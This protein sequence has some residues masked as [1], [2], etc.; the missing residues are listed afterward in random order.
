MGGGALQEAR[1]A[2]GTRRRHAAGLVL[3]AIALAAT[4]TV[5][6]TTEMTDGSGYRTAM[7]AG[8]AG[9]ARA[10]CGNDQYDSEFHYWPQSNLGATAKSAPQK[11]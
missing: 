2:C 9:T 11:R 1:R 10:C 6:R 3:T 4:G 7:H 5:I 8:G